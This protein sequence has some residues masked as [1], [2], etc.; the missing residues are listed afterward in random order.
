MKVSTTRLNGVFGRLVMILR[1]APGRIP[2]PHRGGD[3]RGCARTGRGRGS[4]QVE[5][6]YVVPKYQGS[7]LVSSSTAGVARSPCEGIGE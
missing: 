4:A 1:A 7:P 5:L 6:D 2:N 3:G